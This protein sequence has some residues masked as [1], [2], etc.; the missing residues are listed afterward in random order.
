MGFD[1]R[2]T[3]AL[4]PGSGLLFQRRARADLLG[5]VTRPHAELDLRH[6][7]PGAV[8]GGVMQLPA[9]GQPPG[10][11]GGWERLVETRQR[12]GI[13]LWS[14]SVKQFV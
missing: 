14:G 10:L 13:E 6:I 9:T 1:A 3:A 2:A 5:Q 4:R 7:Q 11:L 8:R 12:V